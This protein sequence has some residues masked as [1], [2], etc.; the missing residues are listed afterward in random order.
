MKKWKV[1]FWLGF[2]FNLL[3]SDVHIMKSPIQLERI[4][5]QQRKIIQIIVDFVDT[6]KK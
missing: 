3:S 4:V 2:Q 6:K 1:T 5:H